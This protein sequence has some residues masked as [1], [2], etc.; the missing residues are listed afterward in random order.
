MAAFLLYRAYK[1]ITSRLAKYQDNELCSTAEQKHEAEGGFKRKQSSTKNLLLLADRIAVG[2][3]EC[4]AEYKLNTPDI[5]A[6]SV[7]SLALTATSDD[8]LP[9][10]QLADLDIGDSLKCSLSKTTRFDF[11]SNEDSGVGERKQKTSEFLSTPLTQ[12]ADDV[13]R[14]LA[15]YQVG[16][17]AAASPFKQSLASNENFEFLS[18][19]L[20]S[21]L[22]GLKHKGEE[23]KA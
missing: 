22:S 8:G 12:C 13:V 11:L 23:Q 6:L 21:D 15:H 16:K 17:P 3:L 19:G 4:L 7:S 18:G 20:C 9:K 2:I 14:S 5:G 1:A 10:Y